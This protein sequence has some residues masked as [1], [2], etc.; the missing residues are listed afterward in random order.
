[1]MR[2]SGKEKGRPHRSRSEYTV[3]MG[4]FFVIH[5]LWTNALITASRNAALSNNGTS[6]RSTT[7]S[8]SSVCNV[9]AGAG[10]G[11]KY[12]RCNKDEQNT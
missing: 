7:R 1:M 5:A 10:N 12:H 4:S 9:G 6:L 3:N 11:E 8:V 2:S